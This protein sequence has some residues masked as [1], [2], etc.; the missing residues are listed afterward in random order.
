MYC[1][2]Q[3]IALR[4]DSE[5]L[6]TPGNPGNFLALLPVLASHDRILPEHL[7]HP[8]MQNAT[9]C[10]PEVQNEMIDIIGK[11]LIQKTILNEVRKAKFFSIMAEEVTVH[12]KEQIP[13]CVRFVDSDR[14]VREEFLQFTNS[15]RIT[16]EATAHDIM[17]SLQQLDLDI[18]HVRGQGYDGAANMSSERVGVQARMRQESPLA[19]YVNCNRRCLKLVLARSCKL[20]NVRKITD[21]MTAACLFFNGSPK[22]EELLKNVIITLVPDASRRRPLLDLCKTRWAERQDAYRHFYQSYLYLVKTLEI[23][24]YGTHHDKGFNEELMSS[25]W[26]TK[27]KA[28]AGSLLASLVTFVVAYQLLSHISSL[29]VKLQSKS[30]DI[31]DAYSMVVAYWNMNYE[32]FNCTTLY[33]HESCII[34]S[35]CM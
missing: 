34:L 27:S 26:S 28:D 6:S 32:L 11:E 25:H 7:E 24:A 9:Y 35:T 13:L 16:G 29:A 8:Q 33:L 18:A 10:S 31:V 4:G 2:R 14:N 21:M 15:K 23:I 1:R 5:E 17:Q 12:N 19:V 22:R 30:L 3:C 20:P